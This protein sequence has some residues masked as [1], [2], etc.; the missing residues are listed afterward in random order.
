[1]YDEIQ[2][3]K[4]IKMNNTIFNI[5]KDKSIS[6]K[7]L[8]W[9]QSKNK[10]IFKCDTIFSTA[11]YMTNVE[12]VKWFIENRFNDTKVLDFLM[13][14]NIK[15]ENKYKYDFLDYIKNK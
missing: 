15:F 4:P 11:C 8:K 6:L 13:E 5:N 7:K 12:F 1:M 3:Y 10:D 2:N 14:K 9:L